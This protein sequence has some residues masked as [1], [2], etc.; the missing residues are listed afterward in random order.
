MVLKMKFGVG[1]SGEDS[2]GLRMYGFFPDKLGSDVNIGMVN[3]DESI[4][5]GSAFTDCQRVTFWFQF[6]GLIPYGRIS[7]ISK[8]ILD[9]LENKGYVRVRSSI[10]NLVDTAHHSY[11]NRPESKFP[12]DPNTGGYNAAD[13]FSLVIERPGSNSHYTLKEINEIRHM[14]VEFSHMAYGKRLQEIS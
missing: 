11:S 1:G 3:E 7:S 14:A 6:K 10:N 5:S 13:G 4:S 2:F 8:K 12:L 9:S